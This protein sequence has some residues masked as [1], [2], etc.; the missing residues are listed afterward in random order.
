ML[1][2]AGDLEKVEKAPPSVQLQ[3]IT[4]PQWIISKAW[5][6]CIYLLHCRGQKTPYE[7]PETQVSLGKQI[8]S[9]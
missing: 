8:K 3:V 4:V 5:A 9:S 7:R 6:Q 1:T 2:T